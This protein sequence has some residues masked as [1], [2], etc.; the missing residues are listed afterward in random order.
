MANT[1]TITVDADTKKA[2]SNVK[3]MGG[4]MR[5]AMK[6]VAAAGAGLTVAAAAAAALG[7]EYQE[8]TNTIAAGTGAT[9]EQ[10]EGL[11]QSFK[12]VWGSV[13]QDAA[14]VSAAIADVNTEMGLEGEALEDVT[15]AFLDVSRAMGE[16]A[17]PMI[18]S[19]AD[20]MIAMGEPVEN[21]EKY[22]D[23][24]TAASQAVGVPMTELANK[25]VKFGPQLNELGL[26]LTDATALIANMEA[27]GMD[28]GKMMPG[29]NTA[30]QKL[31]AEGVT[32]ITGGLQDAIAEI[33][34]AET[35]AEGMGKAMDL[36]GAGA[37]IRFKDAID[38]GGFAVGD[39]V[40]AMENSEGKVSDLGASTLTMSDKFDI[41][42][43]RVKGALTPIGNLATSLGPMVIMLPAIATGIS[44]MAASQT[45]A[46]AATWLQTAAMAALNVAMGPIGLIILGVVAAVAAA[47]LIFKNWDKILA[48]LKATWEKVSD[49]ISGVFSSKWAW[50]LP[51]GALIK[52]ILFIKKH[53][54]DIWAA[55]RILAIVAWEK[56]SEVFVDKFGWALPGGILHTALNKIVELWGEVWVSVK[57]KFAAI[58]GFISGIWEDHFGWLRPGGA[59]H[60]A[61]DTF[62]DK[63]SS[64]WDAIGGFVKGP[65]NFIID[66]INKLID[67]FNALEIGWEAKKVRGITVIPG[68]TFAPFDIPHIPKMAAGGIVRSPTLA[69]I[70]EAGPE[71]VVPLGRGGAGGITI[72]ILGPTYGFDDFEE[73]VTEAIQ[74]GVRRGGF[75]GILATA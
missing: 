1:V 12:D 70:G 53:W 58:A 22:L 43:N 49:F 74:D 66:G 11:T 29:L 42:K 39:L 36:F 73:K 38:K 54:E 65:V 60:R 19:V 10:L 31:A 34:N 52:A 15:T 23:Q 48:V 37:G 41:M 40:K 21:T 20:A 75:G 51:G 28:V 55:I 9:G 35:D 50:L 25:V 30:I 47:I 3:G 69:M 71:A 59:I 68:F 57:L 32:D 64:V 7:Q 6:G 72:N 13:P 4:K 8:A 16:D 44:A 24:L 62:R 46:T 56:I 33:Q 67:L 45:I 26:P 5:S 61:L 63:W 18:K 2:E 27:K 17:T 14:T